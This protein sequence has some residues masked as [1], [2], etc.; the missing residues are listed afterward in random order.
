MP[1][2]PW[3]TR[4]PKVG[5]TGPTAA[6]PAGALAILWQGPLRERHSLAGVNRALCRRLI[7]RGHE[8][9]LTPVVTPGPMIA[10]GPEW[11]AFSSRLA[12]PLSRP[13][14]VEVRHAWPPDW[15]PPEEGHWVDADLLRTGVPP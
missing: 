11:E 10:P 9:S 6:A 3:F 15:S 13:S 2:E 5:P 7:G 12:V 8:L 4:P 1:P 14:D